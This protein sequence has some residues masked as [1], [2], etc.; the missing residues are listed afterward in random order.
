MSKDSNNTI[1]IGK[2]AYIPRKMFIHQGYEIYT[3]VDEP[4]YRKN[5]TVGTKFFED[6]QRND[7]VSW[8]T[9]ANGEHFIEYIY[10]APSEYEDMVITSAD[11]LGILRNY[12]KVDIENQMDE[13]QQDY[14]AVENAQ[15]IG[16]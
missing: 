5:K 4:T 10:Q 14:V 3:F 1:I 11:A 9:D 8:G 6:M 12:I 16:E 13:L 7:C 2:I 15:L